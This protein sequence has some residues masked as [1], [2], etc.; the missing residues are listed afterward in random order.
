MDTSAEK[1]SEILKLHNLDPQLAENLSSRGFH[2]GY[3]KNKDGEIEYTLPLPNGRGVNSLEDWGQAQP[4]RITPS[5]RRPV[6]RDHDVLFVFSDAQIDYRRLPD[7]TLRSLHDERAMQVARMICKDVQPNE[8]I[9]LGDTV[10]LTALSRFDPDS[11]HFYRTLGPAFQR[12]HDFYA[13]LR[14]DNP[15]AKIT[16]VDSNHNTRLKK[17]IGKFAMTLSGIQQPSGTSKYPVLSYPYL[18]NLEHIGV[19]WVSGYGGAEYVYGE[20]KNTPP[21]VFK[22]GEITSSSSVAT[23]ESYKNPDTHI[24]RGHSHSIEFAMRT[25]RAGAYLASVVVGTLCRIT[26]EVPSYHS[27][28]DDLGYP[29]KHYENWQQGVMVIEDFNGQYQF[30]HIPINNG[31]AFYNGKVYNSDGEQ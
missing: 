19:D 31:R 22:H 11:D 12:V 18:T 20:D 26:G 1:F 27:S 2:I 8:I 10:D 13:E 5:R 28:V 9:N 7:G 3:I 23:R 6:Q 15:N 4:A 17:F 25:N 30:N 29:V 14:A 24:V 21:I 16:E